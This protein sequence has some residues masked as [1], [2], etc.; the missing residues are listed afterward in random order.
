MRFLVD[1]FGVDGINFFIVKSLNVRKADRLEERKRFQVAFQKAKR[2]YLNGTQSS[3]RKKIKD[4]KFILQ[5]RVQL[6]DGQFSSD[7]CTLSF[8][9]GRGRGR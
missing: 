5:L 9:K 8:S 3:T 4:T 2:R 7:R 1:R 6:P